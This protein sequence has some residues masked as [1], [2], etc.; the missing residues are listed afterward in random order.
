VLKDYERQRGIMF[1]PLYE[2]DLKSFD[3]FTIS[4]YL[5]LL[6]IVNINSIV[7]PDL[8][9]KDNDESFILVRN[10]VLD[11]MITLEGILTNSYR[12]INSSTVLTIKKDSYYKKEDNDISSTIATEM[13]SRLTLE[14]NDTDEEPDLPSL[15]ECELSSQTTYSEKAESGLLSRRKVYLEK[16][17]THSN[18]LT[19]MSYSDPSIQATVDLQKSYISKGYCKIDA[20]SGHIVEERYEI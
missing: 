16:T 4:E 10:I 6:R 13:K 19:H 12:L 1:F 9:E 17:Y 18:I 2:K 8:V 5:S 14:K 20:N 11:D 15:I 3:P 7:E